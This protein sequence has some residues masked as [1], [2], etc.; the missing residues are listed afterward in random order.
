MHAVS[1]TKAKI[2]TLAFMGYRKVQCASW[3]LQT[4]YTAT[5]RRNIQTKHGKPS[6]LGQQFSDGAQTLILKIMMKI[7][8]DVNDFWYVNR[9]FKQLAYILTRILMSYWG[10]QSSIHVYPTLQYK[11]WKRN[12][13]SCHIRAEHCICYNHRTAF[14][15]FH[16]FSGVKKD[17]MNPTF[18]VKWFFQMSLAFTV[19][20]LP[21]R[22]ILVFV[23]HQ[24]QEKSKSLRHLQ[25]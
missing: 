10:E 4:N 1:K 5:L 17:V 24:T 13:T 20:E 9:R 11:K 16:L 2:D 25:K 18:C 8:L 12:C 7:V 23:A 15:D 19:I 14:K 21:T 3:Y 22:R 6:L